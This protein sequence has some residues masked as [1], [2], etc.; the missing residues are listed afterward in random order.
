MRKPIG[1][2]AIARQFTSAH[3]GQAGVAPGDHAAGHVDRLDAG[4]DERL[5]APGRTGCPLRQ[6][7]YTGRPAGMSSI[8]MRLIGTCTASGA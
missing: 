1:E 7:Q 5:G 4:V 6:M 3:H 8:E 2:T